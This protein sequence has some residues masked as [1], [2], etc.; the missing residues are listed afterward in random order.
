M[1]NKLTFIKQHLLYEI[2]ALVIIL[3]HD[4]IKNI[5]LWYTIIFYISI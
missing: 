5:H 4:T 3:Y 2:T 1:I